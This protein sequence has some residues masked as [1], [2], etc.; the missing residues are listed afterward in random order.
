MLKSIKS[1]NLIEVS[2]VL[3]QEPLIFKEM[4]CLLKVKV[5]TGERAKQGF[6][7]ALGTTHI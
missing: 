3:L 4:I 6:P 7:L 2:L 5:S 1:F